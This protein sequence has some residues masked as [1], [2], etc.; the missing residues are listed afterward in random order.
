MVVQ[1]VKGESATDE[2]HGSQGANE[3][4]G[5]NTKGVKCQPTDR[6]N[7]VVAWR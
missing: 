3:E 7:R 5:G 2:L 6:E 4:H 1:Q